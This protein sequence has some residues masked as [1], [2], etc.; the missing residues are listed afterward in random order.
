MQCCGE[1]QYDSQFVTKVYDW[2]QVVHDEVSSAPPEPLRWVSSHQL[3][4]D[5]QK[6][7]GDVGPIFRDGRWQFHTAHAQLF[8]I[9]FKL[10][11]RWFTRVV[12]DL[13]T[14]WAHWGSV[15]VREYT[16]PVSSMLCLHTGCIV[17]QWPIRRLD[18]ID[19]W[20]AVHLKGPATR[21]GHVLDSL[22]A[23]QRDG[24]FGAH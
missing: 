10:R 21:N 20:L 7:S 16:R 2:L 13:L 19:H 5:F 9:R 6:F 3:Y 11:S 12:T 23:A 14:Y 1:G 4:I 22:P 17:V 18:L 24:C 8:P 15:L